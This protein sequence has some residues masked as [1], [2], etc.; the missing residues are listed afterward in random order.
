VVPLP[1]A[2]VFAPANVH[3]QRAAEA[4]D[5]VSGV[6][7]EPEITDLEGDELGHPEAAD[8]GES[9]HEPIPFVPQGVRV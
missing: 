7:V 3:G 8:G 1:F 5:A 4:G 6:E 2:V 9:D